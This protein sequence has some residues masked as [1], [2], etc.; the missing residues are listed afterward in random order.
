MVT[1]NDME[2]YGTRCIVKGRNFHQ[3]QEAHWLNI[4]NIIFK[5]YD[6][7]RREG[8]KIKWILS[9]YGLPRWQ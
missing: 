5:G 9:H 2:A 4:W 1:W 7:G 8:K 3:Q 6:S